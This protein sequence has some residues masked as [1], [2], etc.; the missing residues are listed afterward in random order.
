MPLTQDQEEREYELRIEQMLTNIEKLRSD[1]R[2]ENRKFAFQA[3]AALALALGAG[4]ALAN[5][6]NNQAKPA[7]APPQAPPAQIIIIPGPSTGRQ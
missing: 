5:Y 7:A 3:V 4:V 6:V 1:I 2:Y